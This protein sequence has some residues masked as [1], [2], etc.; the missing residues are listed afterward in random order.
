MQ[1]HSE[2]FYKAAIKSAFP[3]SWAIRHPNI[4][5]G[6]SPVFLVNTPDG[7][8]VCKFSEYALNFHNRTTSE[9]LTLADVPVPLTTVHAYFNAWFE[10]YAYCHDKTLHEHITYGA[11]DAQIFRAYQQ[12]IDIQKKITQIEP[13]K[14][15]PKFCKYA[16]DVFVT[17]QKMRLNSVLA[18]TYGIVH[19]LFSQSGKMRLMHNDLQAKNILVDEKMNV[20]RLIDLDSV[21]LCNESFSVLT[22]LR[23]YPLKNYSELMDYYED[24]MERKLNRRTIMAGLHILNAI[25][26]PQLKLN[27]ML[28]RGYNPPPQR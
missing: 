17:T 3:N 6:V 1:L 16:S 12:A 19:K 4:A 15:N 14:F 23:V 28:W 24:T 5:G 27:Q 2:D 9:I 22:M 8:Q 20:T 13:I 18:N 21:A 7:T 26:A 10:S 25:R 11:T